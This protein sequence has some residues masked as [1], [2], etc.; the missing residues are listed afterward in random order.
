M[1]SHFNFKR[2]YFRMKL[3][4]IKAKK[5]RCRDLAAL[6]F[7]RVDKPILRKISF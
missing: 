1:I 4:F 3:N 6:S 5:G 2:N 7:E